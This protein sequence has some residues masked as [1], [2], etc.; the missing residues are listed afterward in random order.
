MSQRNFCQPF[1]DLVSAGRRVRKLHGKK[2]KVSRIFEAWISKNMGETPR[3]QHIFLHF[4]SF[5]KTFVTD[6]FCQG[7][8]QR[9]AGRNCS[10]SQALDLC[11]FDLG[12]T[13][14][15]APCCGDGFRQFQVW[16]GIFEYELNM[17]WI[18]LNMCIYYVQRNRYEIRSI[19]KIETRPAG[20][21]AVSRPTAVELLEALPEAKFQPNIYSYNA[22]IS[23]CSWG[24]AKC[25]KTCGVLM[26]LQSNTSSTTKTR[27]KEFSV[28]FFASNLSPLVRPEKPFFFKNLGAEKFPNPW[29]VQ[30]S[31]GQGAVSCW[32]WALHIFQQIR[33]PDLISHATLIRWLFIGCIMLSCY[34]FVLFFKL[35][36]GITGRYIMCFQV[37]IFVFMFFF[38]RMRSEGSRFIWGFGGEAVFAESC[39]SVRNRSQP[40]ATVRNRL[41]EGRKAL[42]SGECV[43][44][45]PESVWSWCV[46]AAVILVFAAEVSVWLICVAAVILVFAEE[47]SVWGIC[48]AAVILAFAAEVSVSGICVAAVILAFAEEVSVWGICVAAVILTFA[49][50]VSVWGI[51]VAA[52]ILAF[53]EEVSV[54]G[55]CVAAVILVSAEEVSVWAICGAA[56]IWAFAEEVSV[57]GICVAAVIN[58]G[59]C[60]GGVCVSDLW[61]RSYF[62]VSRGIFCVSDL[63]C[64]SYIGVCSGGVCESDLWRRSYI[65]VSRG[66]FCVSDLWCRSY[67]GVCRAGGCESDLCRRSYIGVCRGGVCESDAEEVSVRVICVNIA[68]LVSAEDLKSV[69]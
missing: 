50:E 39:V 19:Q 21:W 63:W 49:E 43:W 10:D 69:K 38:S 42:H 61:R 22:C 14:P 37:I 24:R 28:P 51:C 4:S 33:E 65:G 44:R 1:G 5:F 8:H 52:V 18:M 59:V 23:A 36:N 67:I 9:T 15:L 57:W 29:P 17:N 26:Q 62:G 66:I 35:R 12:E 7:L 46:I 55:I 2:A 25:A 68:I 58:I 64:R 30:K 48:V 54:W 45:G 31:R 56:A 32:P 41:R 3:F 16:L 27:R 53:A 34:L 6:T 20:G 60:R 47:V 11:H 40:S 13:E